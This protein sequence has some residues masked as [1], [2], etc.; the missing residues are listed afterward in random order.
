MNHVCQ[1][2]SLVCKLL[3]VLKELA[4]VFNTTV[5]FKLHEFLFKVL[6]KE[7]TYSLF[8]HLIYNFLIKSV[9]F[10]SGCGQEAKGSLRTGLKIPWSAFHNDF[11]I[12]SVPAASVGQNMETLTDLVLNY[13]C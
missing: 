6:P 8:V 2:V 12:I 1:K 13:I 5:C 7:H 4:N 11:W 10:R 9:P 3:L